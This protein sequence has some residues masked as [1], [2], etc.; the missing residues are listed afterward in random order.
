VGNRADLQSAWG[1]AALDDVDGV[2]VLGLEVV[3]FD[4]GSVFGV[5]CSPPIL[6]SGHSDCCSGGGL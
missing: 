1:G 5:F 2:A 3:G 6:G 4:L